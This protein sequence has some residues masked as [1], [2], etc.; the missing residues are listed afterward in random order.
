LFDFQNT[1]LR[2][3]RVLFLGKSSTSTASTFTQSSARWR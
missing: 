1:G 2:K 3:I